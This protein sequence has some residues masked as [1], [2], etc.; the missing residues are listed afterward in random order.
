MVQAWKNGATLFGGININDY[1]G[2]MCRDIDMTQD[3]VKAEINHETV[4]QCFS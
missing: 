1:S 3:I 4:V 2:V